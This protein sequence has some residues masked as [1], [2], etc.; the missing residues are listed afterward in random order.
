MYRSTTKATTRRGLNFK[1]VKQVQ[2]IVNANKALKQTYTALNANISSN[3]PSLFELTEITEGDDFNTRDSD[4]INLQT[5]KV[6][7]VAYASESLNGN[8]VIRLMLVRGKFGPLTVSDMPSSVNAE[9]DLDK[10]Q[11]YHDQVYTLNDVSGPANI[12]GIRWYKS[13][14]NKKVPHMKVEYDDD[15]SAS[16]AQKNPIYVF[17]ISNQL[18]TG[19]PPAING[20]GRVKWFDR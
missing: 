4:S 2:K 14:K 5:A 19:N 18:S 8:S 10:I 1:Q 7:L 12:N 11:V 17:A 6:D 15:T 13:F 20:F 9:P 16:E 3:T